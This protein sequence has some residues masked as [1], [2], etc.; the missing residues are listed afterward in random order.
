MSDKKPVALT[1]KTTALVTTILIIVLGIYDLAAVAIGSE[2]VSVSA[3]LVN[4]G[5][6]R[7]MVIFALGFCAGHLFGPLK[8][9][10]ERNGN[11]SK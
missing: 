9:L 6:D 7:P 1:M 10:K 5:A 4:A 8:T 2:A 3:F 11:L